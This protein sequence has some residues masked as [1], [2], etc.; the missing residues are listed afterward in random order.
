MI[1]IPESVAISEFKNN[2]DR[3][4]DKLKKGP[5]LVIQRSQPYGVLLSTEEWNETVEQIKNLQ[6]LQRYFEHKED[7]RRNPPQRTYSLD[8]VEQMAR[9]RAGQI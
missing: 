6:A 2:P 8:E 5:L 9:E 4:S 7:L 3:V 1:P